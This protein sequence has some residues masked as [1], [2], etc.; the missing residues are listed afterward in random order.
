MTFDNTQ[1]D[2]YK[3]ID[4]LYGRGHDAAT[5]L[6]TLQRLWDVLNVSP[7]VAVAYML[8]WGDYNGVGGE[9]RRNLF[10]LNSLFSDHFAK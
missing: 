1:T 3:I 2:A 7:Q 9:V 6:T 10:R 4:S 8:M 5:T